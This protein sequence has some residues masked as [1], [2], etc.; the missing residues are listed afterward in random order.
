M[1]SQ[2]VGR[3]VPTV[4][5]R[6]LLA[7]SILSAFVGIGFAGAAALLPD[8]GIDGTLGALLAL[9]GTIGVTVMLGVLALITGTSNARGAVITVAV[10]L[11]ILTALA[12]W[13][14]MQNGILLTMVVSLLAVLLHAATARRRAIR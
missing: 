6:M 5:A 4:G 10:L 11:A 14:L 9:L 13:F 12:A 2:D 1:S 8:T 3:S 7:I